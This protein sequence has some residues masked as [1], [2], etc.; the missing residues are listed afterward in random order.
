MVHPPWTDEDG[1]RVGRGMSGAPGRADAGRATCD[2][3]RSVSDEL[4]AASGERRAGGGS[5]E[6]LRSAR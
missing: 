5:G 4:R 3:R 2:E 1:A 6:A